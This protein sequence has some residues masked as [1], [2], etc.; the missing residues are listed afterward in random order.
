MTK[1]TK[2]IAKKTTIITGAEASLLFFFHHNYL[3]TVKG[4]RIDNK[5]IMAKVD[6]TDESGHYQENH[7]M[8]KETMI[9][10][11]KTIIIRKN[12]QK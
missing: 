7:E 4:F 10:V 12:T 3:Q 2:P 5:V 6:I 1:N 8:S 9:L 11:K